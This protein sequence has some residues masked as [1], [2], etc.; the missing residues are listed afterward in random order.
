M[1]FFI[2]FCLC[3][4]VGAL[5]RYGIDQWAA[6]RWGVGHFPWPTVAINLGGS[7]L[8][9]FLFILASE[10]FSVTNEWRLILG[11]G[12]LGSFTTFS[13]FSLQ[14]FLLLQ[15]GSWWQSGFYTLISVV[16]GIG[17]TFMGVACGRGLS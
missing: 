16:G 10:K 8:M 17:L 2:P 5:C 6:L 9:G 13:A 14:N 15:E 11:T 12:L 4:V 3:S 1:S 7:F